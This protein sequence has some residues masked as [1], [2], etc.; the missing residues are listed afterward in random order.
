MGHITY[1]HI[2]SQY[3][4]FKTVESTCATFNTEIAN[5]SNVYVKYGLMIA[6]HHKTFTDLHNITVQWSYDSLTSKDFYR[7]S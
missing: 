1:L 6:L 5:V 4:P 3:I 2:F 7:S